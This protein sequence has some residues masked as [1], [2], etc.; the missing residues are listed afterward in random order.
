M[1]ILSAYG[2]FLVVNANLDEQ[3]AYDLTKTAFE[4]I[5][6]IRRV[7]KAANTTSISNAS[8][9]SGVPIH[10]GAQKYIAEHL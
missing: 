2:T 6:E 1:S 8:Q 7:V 4:N 10:P 3:L 5:D 9:L